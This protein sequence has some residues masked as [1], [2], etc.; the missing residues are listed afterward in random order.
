MQ[1]VASYH[2]EFKS[3]HFAIKCATNS[4]VY[5]NDP[6]MQSFRVIKALTSFSPYNYQA[7]HHWAIITNSG[8]YSLHYGKSHELT[9]K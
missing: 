4:L 7:L 9:F 6:M 5:Y 3:Q 2:K 1:L 8:I